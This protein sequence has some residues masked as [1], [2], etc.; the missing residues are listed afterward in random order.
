M[1]KIKDL[2]VG[3]TVV[4]PLVIHNQTKRTTKNKKTYLDIT[5][6]DGLQE[7]NGKVW[8]YPDNKALMPTG[9][10]YNVE[11]TVGEW[12]GN[13]QLSIAHM[14]INYDLKVTDFLPSSGL[15]IDAT[16]KAALTLCDS[17]HDTTLHDLTKAIYT[18]LDCLWATVPAARSIHHAY[19]GGT[20]IHCYHVGS[21]ANAIAKQIPQANIDLCTSGGLLH[22]V[23]KLF[24]Y[25][26][27]GSEI[28]FTNEGQLLEH[29]FLGAEFVD[30]YADNNKFTTTPQNEAKIELLKHIILS[31]H[32]SLEF[33]S[34]VPPMSIEAVIVS[35]ADHIDAST[36]MIIEAA[37]QPADSTWTKRIFG[38]NN[39]PAIL[40]EYTKNI[41]QSEKNN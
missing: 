11:A 3:T 41:M 5:L 25:A 36:E 6:F 20:L 13:K 19:V 14:K 32:G 1:T 7:I 40:P 26:F 28:T 29:V 35:A 31:H 10:V 34:P 15:D 37:E 18:N 23:G 16:Y 39:R 21:I 9:T 8:S 24:S 38:M 4:I 17:I 2:Q 12:Q 30:N 27:K 22:D 33:G